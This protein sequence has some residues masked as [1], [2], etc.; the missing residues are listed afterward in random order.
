MNSIKHKSMAY[1]ATISLVVMVIAFTGGYYLAKNYFSNQLNQQISDSNT[2]LSIVLKEAIFSYDQGL[3][4]DIMNSFVTYAF[5]H[6][7]KAYDHRGKT[8]STSTESAAQ[9]SSQDV[10]TEKVDVLWEGKK[11]G[12][13]EI[14]YRMDANDELLA[15]TRFMFILIS[16]IILLSL[17]IVNW[18]VLSK[19]V[20][21]P[22]KIVADAMSEIAQGGGDLT[23]RLE[24]SGNDE[25]GVLAKGFNDFITNMHSL[26]G[27]IVNSANE[28]SSCSEQ[29]SDK[30]GTNAKATREQLSEVEQVAT[31]LSQ[32]SSATREISDNANTTSDK[33]DSCNELALQGNQIVKKTVEDIHDLGDQ[34]GVTSKKIM[35]L[36]EKSDHINTV[37]EVIKGI[38]EQTNLL[39]LNAAIEAARAGEQGRGF[40]VVADEVRALAQRTQKSTEEIEEIIQDLQSSSESTNRLMN[41]T[42]ETLEK[43]QSESTQ[44]IQA[45]EDIISDIRMINDMNT[46]IATATEEQNVVTADVSGKVETINSITANITQNAKNVGELSTR[47]DQLSHDII[48]D[49]SKFKL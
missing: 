30:A 16:L 33:T 45:I 15:T 26:I 19:S 24:I 10:R 44:A 5:I 7:I 21:N 3:A 4:N 37:L 1:L 46:Q 38:A 18:V 32:M 43:T 49:L 27:R 17:Q 41:S 34:V 35:E 9:P 42:Q 8:I 13:L 2:T 47:I 40:A 48:Q 31:A 23:R 25:I 28:L 11:I 39:A 12:Y 22:I 6:E 20:V 14:S 36:K 29:I